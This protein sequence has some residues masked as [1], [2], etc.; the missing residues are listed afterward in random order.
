MTTLLNIL[1]VDPANQS[2]LV[3]TLRDNT[4]T[5]VRTLDGWISTTLIASADG[6]RVVIHSKWRDITAVEAMRSD[7][8]MIAYFPKVAAL[9]SLDSIV[10]EVAD[11][12]AA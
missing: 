3:E 6:A 1:T 12:T 11:A 9:A 10:G 8:R 7:P 5:V 2:E 4:D